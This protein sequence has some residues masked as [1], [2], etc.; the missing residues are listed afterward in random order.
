MDRLF[1]GVGSVRGRRC[2]LSLKINDVIDFWRVEDLKKNERLLLRAEMI[3]PGRAWLEFNIH[4][5]GDKN[6]LS[7]TAYYDTRSVIGCLY[8]YF[9]LPF[10]YYIFNRLLKQIEMRSG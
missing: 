5:E 9:L 10:H 3:L 8:W 2:R 4:P 1:M 7:L 6:R